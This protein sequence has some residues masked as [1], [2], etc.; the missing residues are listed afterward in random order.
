M[1]QSEVAHKKAD[2]PLGYLHRW[3]KLDTWTGDDGIALITGFRDAKHARPVRELPASGVQQ[4]VDR[5]LERLKPE[6]IAL[7]VRYRLYLERKEVWESGLHPPRC[8][9]S[10]FLRWASSRDIDVQWLKDWAEANG[11]VKP[12]AKPPLSKGGRPAQIKREH[13]DELKK[14]IKAEKAAGHKPN[15]SALC[16]ELG[17]TLGI[18]E[19]SLRA[20]F[21]N[22]PD[23]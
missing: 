19:R 4:V 8:K 16:H 10:Y 15:V 3:F 21:Y 14:Q 18:N 2:D 1:T 13:L 17:R 12:S 23:L 11:Y 20:A 7:N 5:A 6:V 9:P 22:D